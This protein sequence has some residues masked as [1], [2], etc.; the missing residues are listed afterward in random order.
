MTDDPT[1]AAIEAQRS[2][3]DQLRSEVSRLERA[4]VT[5]YTEVEVVKADRDH[6]RA[7]VAEA[8][9]ELDDTGGEFAAQ[10]AI[11][12]RREAEIGDAGG[13]EVRS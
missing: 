12:I 9:G 2:A 1:T 6:L 11:E 13:I 8:C 10:R 7:L 4:L 3:R 5:A